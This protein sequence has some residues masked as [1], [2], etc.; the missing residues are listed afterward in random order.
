MLNKEHLESLS[1]KEEVIAYA[2]DLGITSLVKQRGLSKLKADVVLKYNSLESTSVDALPDA[3]PSVE[4]AAL[5]AELVGESDKQEE[6]TKAVVQGGASI[7]IKLNGVEHAN[8][9]LAAIE[10]WCL[11]NHLPISTVKHIVDKP[12]LNHNGYSFKLIK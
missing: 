7:Q 10:K 6:I 2:E 4:E 9:A 8:I 5:I 3:I 12:W 1:T 11:E